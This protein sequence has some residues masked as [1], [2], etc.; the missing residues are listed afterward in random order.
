[1]RALLSR[2]L[3]VLAMIVVAGAGLYIAGPSPWPVS[4]ARSIEPRGPLAEAERLTVSIFER[5]SPSVVQVAVPGRGTPLA[6]EAA[7]GSS[8][9]GFV[10]DASGHIVTNDHVVQGARMVAV[11]FASGEVVQAEVV[12][13]AP[14]YDLAVLRVQVTQR[15]RDNVIVS[16]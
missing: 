4:V 11:R 13:L 14:N 8:G 9:T 2:A 6:D 5:V 1:M 3:A 10:W 16:R 15:G 7:P 12:G